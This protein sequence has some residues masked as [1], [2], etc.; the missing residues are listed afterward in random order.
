MTGTARNGDVRLAWE[1]LGGAGG[2]PL[3][4]LMGLGVSRFW[5]PASLVEAFVENGFHVVA[6]DTRDAGESTRFTSDPGGNPVARLVNRKPVYTVEDMTDDAVAVLDAVGWASAH[7]FGHSMGGALAQATALRH[8]DRVRTLTTSGAVPCD[9]GALRRLALIDL[10]TLAGLARM[11]FPATRE[12]DLAAAVEMQRRLSGEEFD[13]AA[14]TAAAER[15]SVSGVRDTDAQSRQ[16]SAT[17]HGGRLED[18]R[19]PTQVLHGAQDPLVRPSAGRL[20]ARRIPG[21]TLELLPRS[22]HD[23]ARSDAPRVAELV[24]ALADRV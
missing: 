13:E 10:G 1:D 11:R 17:W 5:W 24:R 16:M 19:V 15:D 22:G 7:L 4:L 8:P 6:F 9:V 20:V 12:G 2:D 14:T 21:S 23:V 3:L 18:L